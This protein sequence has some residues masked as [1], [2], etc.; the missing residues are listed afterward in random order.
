LGAGQGFTDKDL[1]FLQDTAAGRITLSPETL[2]RQLTL[3]EKAFKASAKRWND[4]LKTMDQKMVSTM[5]LSPVSIETAP[6]KPANTG[7]T[8][9]VPTK[10]FNPATGQLE[11]V[12]GGN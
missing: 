3:E 8:N 12:G 5:G 6:E 4:R 7:A 2:R 9:T 11:A 1:E 10:R